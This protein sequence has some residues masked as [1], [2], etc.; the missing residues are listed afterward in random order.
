MVESRK[1]ST[2][3][4]AGVWRIRRE[5][6]PRSA[7]SGAATHRSGGEPGGRRSRRA[8][9]GG[10]TAGRATEARAA[11]A[12]VPLP[13]PR[14]KGCL[15]GQ[16]AAASASAAGCGAGSRCRALRPGFCVARPARGARGGEARGLIAVGLAARRPAAPCH[17]VKGAC[18]NAA[19][20]P[21]GSAR[22]SA[23]S[24]Y[25]ALRPGFLSCAPGQCGPSWRRSSAGGSPACVAA[26]VAPCHVVKGTCRNAPRLSPPVW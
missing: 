7:R 17:V 26:P 3:A 22:G 25:V 18:R 5:C 4:G 15:R 2:G 19:D 20:A 8:G 6:S 9:R 10:C 1:C 12:A 14:C 13:A 23:V 16:A 11:I 21:G 24:R